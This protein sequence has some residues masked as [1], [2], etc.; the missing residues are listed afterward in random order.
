MRSTASWCSAWSWAAWSTGPTATGDPELV[1]AAAAAR[2]QLLEATAELRELA[3]GIHP[4]VLTQDGLAPALAAL[5]D[6][7]PIPVHLHVD[8]A[9]PCPPEVEATAYFVVSEA[10]TN[11]ARH[12]GAG[13]VT[14]RR[15]PDHGRRSGSTCPTTAAAAPRFRCGPARVSPTGS[16]RS[17]AGSRWRVPP[18]AGTRLVV[19]LPCQ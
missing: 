3:R 9:E 13:Q 19:E 15:E 8:V 5:A 1:S 10:L 2:E 7:S 12:S 17:A 11:A 4:S 14:V 16:P 18:G 6:Q